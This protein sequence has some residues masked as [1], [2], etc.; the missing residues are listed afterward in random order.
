MR[1]IQASGVQALTEAEQKIYMPRSGSRHGALTVPFPVLRELFQR[2]PYQFAQARIV[3]EYTMANVVD[4]FLQ[5]GGAQQL[6][7]LITGASHVQYGQRGSGVPARVPKLLQKR[8][9]VVVLLNPERQRIRQEGDVPEADFLWY[10]PA[11]GCTRNCFNR[12]EVA[13]VMDAAGRRRDALPQVSVTCSC[14]L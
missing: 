8:T 4:R 14:V 3:S 10:S 13:R 12:A 1:T 5:D 11:K 9:Q 6:L 7:I 2:G